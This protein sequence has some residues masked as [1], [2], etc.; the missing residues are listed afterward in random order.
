MAYRRSLPVHK[1]E[2]INTPSRQDVLLAGSTPT[3]KRRRYKRGKGW[4]RPRA[5]G[6]AKIPSFPAAVMSLSFLRRPPATVILDFESDWGMLAM[7]PYGS[8]FCRDF[9]RL[10]DVWSYSGR[11]KMVDKST[12]TAALR[13]RLSIVQIF[14]IDVPRKFLKPF[15][16]YA[17][18]KRRVKV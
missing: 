3:Q 11:D 8:M 12:I 18:I 17:T 5:F 16:E 10:F 7:N 1:H 15:H 13:R 2:T 14:Q 9:D 6:N 4:P